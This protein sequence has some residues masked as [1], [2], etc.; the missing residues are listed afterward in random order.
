MYNG[1]LTLQLPTGVK[2]VGF[3]DDITLVVVGESLEAVEIL[4]T[5]A[6]DAVENWMQRK[7]LSIA[8]QKTEL[9]LISNCKVVQKAA[10]I[11]GEHAI[12]SKRELKHLGVMIDDRLNFN[13]HVDYACGKAAKAI[14][15]LSRIM[16][17]NSAISSSKRRLLASVSTSILRY[18]SPAWATAT[19]TRRNRVQVCSTHRLMAMRVASAYRTISSDAVCVIA[20]MVPIVFVLEEDKECYEARGARGA[21]KA[22]RVVTMAKW[23]HE[24]NT[25]AKG[26]WTHRLIPNLVEW[27]N[28]DHGEVNFHLTQF[29]SGHGCFK[30]Y[31]HRFGHAGSPFC[32]EC[33]DVEES[34]EHV[35]F[36]CPRFTVERSEMTAICGAGIR[37]DNIVTRMCRDEACWNAVNA[38][39]VKIMS[40]LQRKWREQQMNDRRDNPGQA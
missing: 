10:I 23:Q 11:V 40:F 14:T 25:T 26:R 5:E 35:V 18:A 17:N 31:L 33:G 12:D 37:A 13:S 29:L 30:K 22:A 2:I 15:A 28:R 16:P 38:A 1:V 36:E 34:P 21:R 24:W 32:P 39:V 8:H 3:A 6:V 27:V 19:K 20:G 7:K 9:V 4:A